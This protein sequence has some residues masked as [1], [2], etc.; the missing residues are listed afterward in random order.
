MLKSSQGPSIEILFGIYMLSHRDLL[1]AGLNLVWN[2]K[3]H[4]HCLDL[5]VVYRIIYSWNLRDS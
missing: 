4:R 3:T 1:N 2:V 5:K